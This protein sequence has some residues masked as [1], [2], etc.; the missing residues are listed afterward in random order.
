MKINSF[1]IKEPDPSM[2]FSSFI[3]G[4]SNRLARAMAQAVGKKPGIGINPLYIYGSRGIGKSHLLNAVA[5]NHMRKGLKILYGCLGHEADHGDLTPLL[6]DTVLID[7]FKSDT[8]YD[9]GVFNYCIDKGIQV[10]ITGSLS[11]ENIQ[12]PDLSSL[13][14]NR[15]KA[16]DIQ[17]PEEELR[18]AVLKARA[19]F[20]GISLP[21]DTAYFIAENIKGNVRTLIGAFERV[22]AMSALAGQEVSRFSAI[23]ALRDYLW[24]EG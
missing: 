2:T 3:E 5:N 11:P 13:I 15:G 12:A 10:V 23:Q 14:L 22:K 24:T 16:A 9:T 1:L 21:D 8:D 18:V 7:D 20:E 6:P 17:L 4:E 19:E